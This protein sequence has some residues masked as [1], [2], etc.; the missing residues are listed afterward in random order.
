[1]PAP[2]RR[3]LLST[4][5]TTAAALLS[6][7]LDLF[8]D[9][10]TT[11]KAPEFQRWIPSDEFDW[12]VSPQVSL[13]FSRPTAFDVDQFDLEPGMLRPFTPSVLE[14][15]DLDT[16]LF[17]RREGYGKLTDER[18]IDDRYDG[19]P[20]RENDGVAAYATEDGVVAV[21]EGRY[22]YFGGVDTLAIDAETVADRL[23]ENV[24]NPPA[25]DEVELDRE[26][27]AAALRSI[28]A[29]TVI[30]FDVGEEMLR[31]FAPAVRTVVSGWDVG[32]DRT[33]LR[34]AAVFPSEDDRDR[35]AIENWTTDENGPEFSAY[36]DLTVT[37]EGRIV[38]V[39]GEA[40]TEDVRFLVP[41]RE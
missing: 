37:A 26:A 13:R 28:G 40:A 5:A 18:T 6:G 25:P 29:P 2:K 7:C 22:G 31:A 12:T 30:R 39:E 38:L 10:E 15:R 20:I 14:R 19:E 32:S 1:M 41:S 21:G 9:E 24:A 34:T 27:Y 11:S 23:V 16:S 3:I 8:E 33:K 36:D 4:V 17:G 35:D